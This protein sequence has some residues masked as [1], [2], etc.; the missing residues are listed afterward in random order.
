MLVHSNLIMD[1]IDL[2]G[3][4]SLTANSVE[5]QIARDYLVK[6]KPDVVVAILNAASLERNLYLLAELI[7]LSP[8]LVI[9]LNMVDVAEQQG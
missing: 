3:T 5:E 7:E 4:Y 2:P 6:E 8:R 1:I 9:G